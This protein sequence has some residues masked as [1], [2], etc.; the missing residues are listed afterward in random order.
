MV[1]II[2]LLVLAL[3]SCGIGS[4]SVITLDFSELP[5][6]TVDGL[7]Y[8]G[9]T[10][11]YTGGATALYNYDTTLGAMLVTEFDGSCVVRRFSWNAHAAV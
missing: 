8:K 1:K 6:Q 4:A 3:T 2:T 11:G 10:F 9:V 5:Q 7:T